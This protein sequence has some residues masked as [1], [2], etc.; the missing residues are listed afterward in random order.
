MHKAYTKA[1][2]VW[3]KSTTQFKLPS[4]TACALSKAPG[5]ASKAPG[6]SPEHTSNEQVLK[7]DQDWLTKQHEI[8]KQEREA[9]ERMKLAKLNQKGGNCQK[10]GVSTG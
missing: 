1:N 4:K 9:K 2:L 3:S 10:P 6:K 5:T 8:T 7:V